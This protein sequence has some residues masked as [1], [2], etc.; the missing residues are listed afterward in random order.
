M[1][2]DYA[3]L[4]LGNP[5]QGQLPAAP[6]L[7]PLA[8]QKALAENTDSAVIVV[9][10]PAMLVLVATAKV[11]LDVQP[12]TGALDPGNSPVVLPADQRVMFTLPA[13][14]YKLKTLAYA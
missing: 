10:R 9:D 11:R 12:S 13:G 8:G 6:A 1:A 4:A 5:V 14:S 7:P 3:V 2:L